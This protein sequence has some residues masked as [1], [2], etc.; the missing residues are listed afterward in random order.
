MESKKSTIFIDILLVLMI[1][2]SPFLY[3][4]ST[5]MKWIKL[6][7]DIK[8]NGFAFVF[9]TNQTLLYCI[10]LDEKIKKTRIGT[11]STGR[12]PSI[13]IISTANWEA[14]VLGWAKSKRSEI[15][16]RLIN[17]KDVSMEYQNI[18]YL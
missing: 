6:N 2:I 14:Y 11:F 10:K 16:D 9:K 15:I 17:D 5:I 8:N 7:R 1:P 13:T 4:I 12:E 18:Y 3:V